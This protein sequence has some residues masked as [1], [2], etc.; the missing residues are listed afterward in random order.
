MFRY[1]LQDEGLNAWLST[2]LS[3]NVQSQEGY[4]ERL[5]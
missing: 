5:R 4:A 2:Y 1:T 3:C